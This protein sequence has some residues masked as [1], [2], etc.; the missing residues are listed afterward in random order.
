MGEAEAIYKLMPSLKM[1]D[2][3]V[4]CV[5]LQTGTK[6]ER[7]KFLMS[8]DN[9][10]NWHDKVGMQVKGK[11]GL[12]VE[13]PDILD[14]YCRKHKS[15]GMICPSHFAKIYESASTIPKKY[16]KDKSDN[17]DELESDDEDCVL[18]DDLDANTP[19][20]KWHFVMSYKTE[21]RIT[22][23]K[24][25][26]LDPV[27]PGEPAYMRRRE[28]PACL[29]FHKVK[30]H[31]DPQK[32]FKSQI[33]LYT[34]FKSEDEL[35]FDDPQWVEDKFKESNDGV[36]R[37]IQIVKDKVM[38]HLESVEE[39]RYFVDELHKNQIQEQGDELDAQNVQDELECQ[40][41]DMMEHPDFAHLNPDELEIVE[42]NGRSLNQ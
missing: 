30:E 24:Y 35:H 17:E 7:S 2:S 33:M 23:P 25:F 6:N 27:Y 21:H 29:R 22:L 20:S 36:N 42:A 28:Y 31:T 18:G 5:F 10:R 8:I 39:A 1:K 34:H 41:E 12:V 16:C 14:K 9:D 38:E 15:L 4:G 37:N 11:D 26:K 3:N 13:K 40:E 32:Y 19:K